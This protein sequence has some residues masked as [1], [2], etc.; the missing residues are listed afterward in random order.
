MLWPLVSEATLKAN[1]IQTVLWLTY[2][3]NTMIAEV[4][5]TAVFMECCLG[6]GPIVSRLVRYGLL[7]TELLDE[8]T[9]TY[10]NVG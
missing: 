9:Y 8:H 6:L 10:T 1:E 2:L 5:C 7:F 3:I 4:V